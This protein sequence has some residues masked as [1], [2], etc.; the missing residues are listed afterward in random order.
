MSTVISVSKE[1]T[2]KFIP[3]AVGICT[4]SAK[5]RKNDIR[6]INVISFHSILEIQDFKHESS[7]VSYRTPYFAIVVG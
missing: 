3:N 6:L 2:A 4:D 5:V 1:K 7:L